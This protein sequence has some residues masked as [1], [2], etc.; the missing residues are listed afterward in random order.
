VG[1]ANLNH[2]I[3]RTWNASASYVRGLRFVEGFREPVF[4][5]SVMGR[6][7]GYIG[8]RTTLAFFTGWANGGFTRATTRGRRGYDTVV[9]GTSLQVAL[10]TNLAWYAQYLHYRY[11]FDEQIALPGGLAS[12]LQRNSVQTGLSFWLPLLR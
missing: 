3:G 1:S 4:Q 8:P 7:G 9:A 6:L 10:T 12:R 5:D 11:S 2:R